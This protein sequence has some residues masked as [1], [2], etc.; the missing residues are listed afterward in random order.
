M[1]LTKPE[2]LTVGP[3]TGKAGRPGF[4]QA[5]HGAGLC[6]MWFVLRSRP[7][8]MCTPLCR[9]G[10]QLEPQVTHCIDLTPPGLAYAP[11]FGR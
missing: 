6:F 5:L 4:R 11:L 10:S 3:L 1:R 8:L 7:G 9:A 2:A